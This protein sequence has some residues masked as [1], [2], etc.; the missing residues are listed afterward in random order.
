MPPEN[1]G[2]SQN[3]P[4]TNTSTSAEGTAPPTTPDFGAIANAAAASHI[5]RFEKQLPTFLESA[6]K[7]YLDKLTA[8]APA[9][10]IPEAKKSPEYAALEQKLAELEKRNT[11]SSARAQAAE[12]K[13]REDRAYGE[14]RN[15]LQGKVNPDFLDMVSSHLFQVQ[16]AID[17]EEDGTPVFATTRKTLYG[18]EDLRLPIKEGVDQWLRSDAAK[19][20]IPAPGSSG[21]SGKP[22]GSSGV[23]LNSQF[24]PDKASAEEKIMHAMAVA[25]T[26]QNQGG[27]KR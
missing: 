25:E 11:E 10:E 13:Q 14:L 24:D 27:F 23:Q 19:P 18:D 20:F 6:L 4:D 17:F 9:K 16:R 15:N 22:K 5:K 7:P 26:Y 3:A 1:E 12:R 21:A 8:A 2:A